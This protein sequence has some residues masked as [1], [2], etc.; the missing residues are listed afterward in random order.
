M[1]SWEHQT[2]KFHHQLKTE[3]HSIQCYREEI[4]EAARRRELA[5]ALEEQRRRNARNVRRPRWNPILKTPGFWKRFKVVL[6]L[7][8][9]HPRLLPSNPRSQTQHDQTNAVQAIAGDSR[10][11]SRAQFQPQLSATVPS[12]PSFS[13]S[14]PLPPSTLSPRDIP[15]DPSLPSLY[16]PSY[17][18]AVK[19][20]SAVNWDLKVAQM[21]RE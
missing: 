9:P 6:L 16:L 3:I 19:M 7:R 20:Q 4:A 12:S 14:A 2:L 15:R 17:D 1:I 11:P 21:M 10:Y 8:I 5:E 13:P 18:E